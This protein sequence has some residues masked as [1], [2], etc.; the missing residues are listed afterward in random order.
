[1]CYAKNDVEYSDVWSARRVITRKPHLC[2]DCNRAIPVGSE[3]D[4]ISSLYDGNWD[5]LYLCFACI[6]MRAWIYGHE[7]GIEGC[8]PSEAMID[9]IGNGEIRDE[10]RRIRREIRERAEEAQETV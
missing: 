7:I 4:R 2:H 5:R 8:E 3:A 9:V 10:Y 1:M 6:Y